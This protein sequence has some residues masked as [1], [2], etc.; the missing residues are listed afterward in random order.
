MLNLKKGLLEIE[1]GDYMKKIEYKG[2]KL[3]TSL[4]KEITDVEFTEIK[5]EYYSRPDFE[6]VKKQFLSIS[7]GGVKND[8]I[9]NYYV[10]DLMAKTLVHFNKWSIEEVL[11]YKPLVEF[12][13]GKSNDNK[14]VFPDTM[15][16]CQ[17]LETAFRLCGKGVASK[18][19][20]FPIKTI[21]EILENYNVNNNWYDFSCGWGARLTGAL[22]HKVNYYGTDPNYLLTERLEQLGKDYKE[23]LNQDTIIDI[24]TQGSEVFNPDWENKMGL[25]FSSPPYFY[26]EDYKIGNQSFKQGISYQDWKDNYLEPTFRNIFYYLIQEGY[27]IL[28]INN[29]KDFKLVED[30]IKI[31]EKVGFVLIGEHKLN[32]IKRVYGTTS[33]DN[34]GGFND[35]SERIMIFIKNDYGPKLDLSCLD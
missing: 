27:F 13:M 30:S 7:K 32:N 2:K 3:E 28:N 5:K 18:P 25:A 29:F 14:K 8:K 6:E 4:Y 35:N 10:K 19:A 1:T 17:K 22:K 20:N 16:N 21:D 34:K 15:T 9:T 33:E 31:A 12:F 11:E 24:R 23:T 26:L